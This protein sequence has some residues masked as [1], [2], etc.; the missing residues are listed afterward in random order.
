MSLRNRK[1]PVWLRKPQ[2]G[3]GGSSS[4]HSGE[5]GFSFTGNGTCQRIM[6]KGDTLRGLLLQ[7]LP[8]AMEEVGKGAGLSEEQLTPRKY[9]AHQLLLA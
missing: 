2:K 9:V 8:A 1:R 5:T 4:G 6:K 7:C 3:S